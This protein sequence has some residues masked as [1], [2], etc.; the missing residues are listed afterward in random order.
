MPDDD[1]PSY[2]P[3]GIGAALAGIPGDEGEQARSEFAA[4]PAAT[5]T[6]ADASA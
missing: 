6:D 2:D 3:T 4:Q 5:E 1:Q